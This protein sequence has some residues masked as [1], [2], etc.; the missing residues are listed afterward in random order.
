MSKENTTRSRWVWRCGECKDIVVSYSHLRHD[1][2]F[3]DCGKSSVD[4]EEH[5][6]RQMGLVEVLSVKK[7]VD[8]E[9]IN[10]E[11]S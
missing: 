4:L 6:C 1:M 8:G 5:Y 10:A 9:W 2:N 3:C 11:E 7:Y